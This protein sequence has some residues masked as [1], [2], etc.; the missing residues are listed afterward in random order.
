M[1]EYWKVGQFIYVSANGVV[2]G[3]CHSDDRESFIALKQ[4]AA[5]YLNDQR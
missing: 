2:I 3:R 4:K 5:E 1:I